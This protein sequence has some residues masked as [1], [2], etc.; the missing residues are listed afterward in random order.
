MENEQQNIQVYNKDI[1]QEE[2][3]KIYT[4]ISKI[5]GYIRAKGNKIT[6]IEANEFLQKLTAYFTT[7]AMYD[8]KKPVSITK[9]DIYSPDIIIEKINNYF[10]LPD[11]APDIILNY[12]KMYYPNQDFIT[13]IEK[14]IE[15]LNFTN[16]NQPQ[17]INNFKDIGLKIL[18]EYKSE[19]ANKDGN[20]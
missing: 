10:K 1:V 4:K 12:I 20:I 6:D 14:K 17:D 19:N 11:V 13:L 7:L 8:N 15:Q 2:K 5:V 9:E 18:N 16:E 3:S